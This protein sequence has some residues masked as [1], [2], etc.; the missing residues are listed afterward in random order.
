[1]TT[2]HEHLFRVAF[3][4]KRVLEWHFPTGGTLRRKLINQAHWQWLLEDHKAV[5]AIGDEWHATI[6][7]TGNHY[8]VVL[9]AGR[10]R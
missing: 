7:P 10:H 2:V 3:R 4:T 6:Y 8:I 9:D 5:E 1:M